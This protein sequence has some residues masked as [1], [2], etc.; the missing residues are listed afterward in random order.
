MEFKGRIDK[1]FAVQSGTSQ[2]G[3]EW[4]KQEFVFEYFEH[5]TDRYSDK[6]VLSLAGDRIA[7]KDLHEG[8][9][10]VVGFGHTVREWQGRWF[11]ELRVYKVEKVSTA[12]QKGGGEGLTETRTV[13]T[14]VTAEPPKDGVK[15]G[16]LPF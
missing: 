8:D 4:R 7:E 14:V 12:I 13:E 1:V 10:C 3:N 15:E 6:V 16:D 2:R 11:N 5:E 9:E